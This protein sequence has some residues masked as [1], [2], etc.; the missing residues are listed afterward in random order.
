MTF[1]WLQV[2]LVSAGFVAFQV[3]VG[4]ACKPD[5]SGDHVST[6]PL[7][8]VQVIEFD[9]GLRCA[10]YLEGFGGGISCDW[11]RWHGNQR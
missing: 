9:D 5:V 6:S 8:G 3:G 4:F 1:T 10:I 7:G 11:E 2:L